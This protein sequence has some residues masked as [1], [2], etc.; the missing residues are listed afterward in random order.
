MFRSTNFSGRQEYFA[1]YIDKSKTDIGPGEY[2]A[3]A[4]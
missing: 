3:I 2:Q 4:N 1:S